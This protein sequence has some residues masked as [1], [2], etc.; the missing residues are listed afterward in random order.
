MVEDGKGLIVSFGAKLDAGKYAVESHFVRRLLDPFARE[1]AGILV[2]FLV[3]GDCRLAVQDVRILRV[4]L[5]G[6]VEFDGS[7]FLFISAVEEGRP[8]KMRNRRIRIDGDHLVDHLACQ[9]KIL[10]SFHQRAGE[11]RVE[12]RLVRRC[13]C[14]HI[15]FFGFLVVTNQIES[16]FN[17]LE[18]VFSQEQRSSVHCL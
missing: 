16:Q 6:L 15:E 8:L 5:E 13:C 18:V 7:F 1:T 2:V 14:F 12:F 10:F 4:E 9:F 11:R 17:S 3:V